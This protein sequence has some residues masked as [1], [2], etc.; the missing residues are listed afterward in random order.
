MNCTRLLYAEQDSHGSLNI[1]IFGPT[2]TAFSPLLGLSSVA[3]AKEGTPEL[4]R[5]D[6]RSRLPRSDLCKDGAFFA[7]SISSS[8]PASTCCRSTAVATSP[9]LITSDFVSPS[10]KATDE[11][12]KAASASEG[13]PSCAP[14]CAAIATLSCTR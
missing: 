8:C 5:S 1:S 13:A 7:C 11:R 12:G 10:H 9:T 6:L 3:S 14:L 2:T 4:P